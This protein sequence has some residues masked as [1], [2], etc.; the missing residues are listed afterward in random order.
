[1]KSQKYKLVLF[2]FLFLVQYFGL[3]IVSAHA[4]YYLFAPILLFFF[5]K[6]YKSIQLFRK[7]LLLF[8]SFITCSCIYSTIFNGQNLIK[9]FIASLD[10]W[11][12]ISVFILAYYKVSLR[13][14][15][16]LLITISLIF[17][18]CY[19][20][21]WM[22]YP[23]VLFLGATDET[24]ISGS[25]FRMRMQGSICAYILYF[26]GLNKFLLTKKIKSIAYM[27]LG[28]IPIIVMGFRS[29][30]ALTLICSMILFLFLS[31]KSK[32]IILWA[33]PLGGLLYFST[34]IPVVS[35]KIDEMMERQ[36]SN[37]TFANE[38]YIRYI[39]FDY[40]SKEVFTKPGEKIFGGGTPVYDGNHYAK[41]LETAYQIYG[42]YWVDLGLIG[43]SFIIG[44]PAV[45]IL[46]WLTYKSI[47]F[48]RNIEYQFLRFTL[49]TVFLGSIITSK[50]IYRTG[51]LIIIGIILYIIYLS[52]LKNNQ[53]YENRNIDLSQST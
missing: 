50:E 14:S 4:F 48:C 42:W 15:K 13:E 3:T 9:T 16:K 18:I 47:K 19:I 41:I 25:Y 29:L 8:L 44:I 35:D 1:M 2:L 12:I 22:I 7:E 27:I 37:Q 40:F 45:L 43:L 10:F 23:T 46:S 49:I 31:V 5:Y 24:N 28:G 38:D 20:I 51:N 34:T 39:E 33:I 30:T 36:D 21:Q 32:K 53:Q 52:N 17:C 11:G 6:K 26:Y